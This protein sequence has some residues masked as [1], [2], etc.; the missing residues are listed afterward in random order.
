M[1]TIFKL[2]HLVFQAMPMPRDCQV[3]VAPTRHAKLLGGT[4]GPIDRATMGTKP[5]RAATINIALSASVVFDDFR[6]L[7]LVYIAGSTRHSVARQPLSLTY[8]RYLRLSQE[9]DR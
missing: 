5:D 2:C 8:A 6:A 1:T 3:L 7:S 4:S 9:L